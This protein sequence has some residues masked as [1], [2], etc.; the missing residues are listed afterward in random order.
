MSKTTIIN[1]GLSSSHL[2]FKRASEG[3]CKPV[4]ELL[5][6]DQFIFRFAGTEKIEKGKRVPSKSSEWADGAWWILAEDHRKIIAAFRANGLNLGTTA[7]SALAV[8]PSWSLMNVSIKAFLLNDMYVFSGKGQTQYRDTLP[9]GMTTTL[10]GW[11]DIKQVYIPG[12]RGASK[13][14]IRVTKQKVVRSHSFGF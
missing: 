14:N 13:R 7:R 6:A 11:P 8:Q 10:S 2:E 9:N 1:D 3:I 12:M 4:V 5:K